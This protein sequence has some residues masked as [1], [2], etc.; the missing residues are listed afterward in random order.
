MRVG[1]AERRVGGVRNHG[2]GGKIGGEAG[3]A[4]PVGMADEDGRAI[5]D[6]GACRQRHPILLRSLAAEQ[7]HLEAG[8]E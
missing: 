4:E 3:A 7:L 5:Y 2:A 6:L 8:G 1:L